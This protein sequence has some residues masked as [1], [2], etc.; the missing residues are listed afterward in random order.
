MAGVT[1]RVLWIGQ[2][3]F[4]DLAPPLMVVPGLAGRW[5]AGRREWPRGEPRRPP[6][7]CGV[8]SGTHR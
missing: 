3:P 6:G 8:Q 1:L 5:P 4:G 2:A 7:G